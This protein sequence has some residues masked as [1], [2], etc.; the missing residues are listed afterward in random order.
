[1]ATAVSAANL[2]N[3]YYSVRQGGWKM[4]RRTNAAGIALI[5]SFEGVKLDA[6]QDVAGI[7]TIGYGHIK[8]VTPGM[9]ITPDEAEQTLRDDMA[10]TESAVENATSAAP[11]SDNNFAAMVALAFNIGNGNYR[12]STV[13]REH[14]AG[15][16]AKAADAFLMWNKAKVEGVL[17]PVAGLTRR[18]AAERELYL[19]P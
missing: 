1:M 7:W 18:R 11:T 3:Q 10:G 5:K 6:Y 17:Q 9:H 2:K 14:L 15:N 19:K 16:H 4:S 8:G 12:Q 13:L